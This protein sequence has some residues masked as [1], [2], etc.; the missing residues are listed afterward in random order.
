[1]H[2]TGPPLSR[3]N[4]QAHASAQKYPQHVADY[5]ASETPNMAMLG[6]YPTSP[7]VQWTSIS[8]LM[9]RPKADS[10][11]RRIIVDLSY[12][13]GDNVNAYVY[14]NMLFGRHC[15]HCLPTVRDTVA[16]IELQGFRVM[17]ATIDIKRAY[18]NVLVCPLALPLLGG[19]TYIDTAM[20]FG[21]RNSSLCHNIIKELPELVV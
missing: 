1:M 10:H 17:L 13:Q 6:P 14:K 2:Y 11:K 12:P 8:P 20:P 4:K 9:T 19:H 18:C 3:Q 16:A 5:V 7:F 21:A 15:E